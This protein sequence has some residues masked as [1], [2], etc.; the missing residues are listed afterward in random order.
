[1]DENTRKIVRLASADIDGKV[2]VG[3]ALRK[4]RGVSFMLSKAICIASGT[5]RARKIGT[6]S[7]EELKKLE[8]AIKEP[9]KFREIPGWMLNRRR[10]IETGETRHISGIEIELKKREDINLMRRIKSYKGIRHEHGLPVRGQ[11]TRSSFRKHAT[12]GVIK[13]AIKQAP[14][15]EE[16]KEK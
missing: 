11:R 13:K 7:D 16:K 2:S 10:D 9:Q 6:L 15:K 12:V 3:N 8:S 5:E 14:K 4:V 1:M